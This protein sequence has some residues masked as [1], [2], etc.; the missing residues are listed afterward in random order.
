[1]FSV[2]ESAVYALDGVSFRVS[3]SASALPMEAAEEKP[4]RR[5]KRSTTASS[6]PLM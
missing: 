1:M 2:G 5:K 6:N 3:D 4:C